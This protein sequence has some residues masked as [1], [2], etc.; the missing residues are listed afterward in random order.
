MEKLLENCFG[1]SDTPEMHFPLSLGQLWWKCLRRTAFSFALFCLLY[2]DR[3]Q[4][5]L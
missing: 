2:Q 3:I 4:K 5:V 1:A